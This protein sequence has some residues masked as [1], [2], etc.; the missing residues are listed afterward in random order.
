MA[1]SQAVQQAPRENGH[2]ATTTGHSAKPTD[3]MVGWKSLFCELRVDYGGQRLSVVLELRLYVHGRVELGESRVHL[4]LPVALLGRGHHVRLVHRYLVR[5]V[6][7]EQ[8]VRWSGQPCE[9]AEEVRRIAVLWSLI[10]ATSLTRVSDGELLAE[11]GWIMASD[12]GARYCAH[13]DAHP[14]VLLLLPV[15][16]HFGCWAR[17]STDVFVF[18]RLYAQREGISLVVLPAD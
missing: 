1:Q 3:W 8:A 15:V 12:N 16:G 6:D 17:T 4:L 5:L 13:P 9:R 2:S 11:L 10:G 18:P 7:S 14:D